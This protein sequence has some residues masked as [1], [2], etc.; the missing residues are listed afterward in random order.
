MNARRIRFLDWYQGKLEAV[1]GVYE[2]MADA[3]LR[4]TTKNLH[5]FYR[6]DSFTSDDF[7]RQLEGIKDQSDLVVLDHLHYVDSDDENENRGYKATVKQIRDSALKFEKP[8]IVVAHVRKSDRRLAQLLP[9]IEDFHGSSDIPKMATKAIMLAP[10]YGTNTG[11]S[12]LWSTFMQVGK[13]RMD[14]SVTRYVARL[15]FNTRSDSY[16]DGYSL[17][18]LTDGG[19]Q[20]ELLDD[21]DMPTWKRGDSQIARDENYQ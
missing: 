15:D 10:D 11:D 18:R 3:E 4:E 2:D 1:L 7:C 8:V 20:F 19:R 12:A 14:N 9:D 13:C 16:E 6:I 21:R 5:T 17:G